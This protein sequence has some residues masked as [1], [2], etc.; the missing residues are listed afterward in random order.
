MYKYLVATTVVVVVAVEGVYVFS[1]YFCSTS[2]SSRRCI[3][4]W[5]PTKGGMVEM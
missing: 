1:G 2:G 4:I 5:W 3:R